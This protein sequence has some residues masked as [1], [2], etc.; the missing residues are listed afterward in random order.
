M[1]RALRA[2]TP[3]WG[4]SSLAAIRSGLRRASVFSRRLSEASPMS[5]PHASTSALRR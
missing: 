2:A 5:S 4:G 1:L 3:G